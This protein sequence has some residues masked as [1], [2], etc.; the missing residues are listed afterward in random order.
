MTIL[1]QSFVASIIYQFELCTPRLVTKEQLKNKFIKM[2]AAEMLTFFTYAPIM[3]GRLVP[4]NNRFWQL[5]IQ[6]RR[7]LSLITSPSFNTDWCDYLDNLI[8]EHHDEYIELFGPLKPKHH[9][10]LHYSKIIKMMGPLEHIQ[11]IRGEAK[12]REGKLTSNSVSIRV[13]TC[14]T[15]SIKQQLILSNRLLLNKGFKFDF[16]SGCLKDL[17]EE[18]ADALNNLTEFSPEDF[19]AADMLQIYNTKY[20]CDFAVRIDGHDELSMFAQ[21]KDI[22]V[23]TNNNDVLFFRNYIKT[24]SFFEHFFAYEVI[25]ISKVIFVKQ[26]DLLNHRPVLVY[27]RSEKVYFITKSAL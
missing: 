26:S 5:L 9:F 16:S 11:A 18:T 13:N 2:S 7:I 22:L 27:E 6:M 4:G 19:I 17:S 10:M 1:I 20:R 3:F 21:I 14:K 15:I 25:R 12:H 24:V 23:S 8:F